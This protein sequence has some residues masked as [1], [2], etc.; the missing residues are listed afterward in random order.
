MKKTRTEWTK[1]QESFLVKNYSKMYKEDIAKILGKTI[2]AIY[3]RRI[4]L[5]IPADNNHTGRKGLIPW[6]KKY[7]DF[8]ICEVCDKKFKHKGHKMKFCSKQCMVIAQKIGIITGGQFKAGK[9]HPRHCWLGGISFEPYSPEFNKDLKNKI[10]I[11]DNNTCQLC[12]LI[13]DKKIFHIHHIDYDKKNNNKFNLITLCNSCHSKTNF[14]R[15]YWT[16]FFTAKNINN[17]EAF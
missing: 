16:G 5:N 12:S 3:R 6:N 4:T 17:G 13:Q 1:E 11:R 10:K 2:H 9:E 14:N 8:W 7:P 15:E